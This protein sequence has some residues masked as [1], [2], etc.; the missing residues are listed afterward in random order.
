[1]CDG[2]FGVKSLLF[3]RPVMGSPWPFHYFCL[4]Q[5]ATEKKCQRITMT[6]RQ[7]KSNSSEDKNNP[8]NDVAPSFLLGHVEGSRV[9]EKKENIS[10]MTCRFVLANM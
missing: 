7:R 9:S 6:Q 5:S 1:M 4:L 10:C 2:D 3:L 8:R